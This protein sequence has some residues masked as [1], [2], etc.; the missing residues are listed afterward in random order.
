MNADPSRGNELGN[1]GGRQAPVPLGFGYFAHL[2]IYDYA[3]QFAR[4]GTFVDMGCGSGYGADY[5]S[6]RIA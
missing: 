5:G 6:E 4:S 3:R 1:F 2:A